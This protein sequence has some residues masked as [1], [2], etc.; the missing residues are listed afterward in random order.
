MLSKTKEF[1]QIGTSPNSTGISFDIIGIKDK[2]YLPQTNGT[3]LG[4]SSITWYCIKFKT[5]KDVNMDILE[6]AIRVGVEETK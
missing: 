1:Y 4:K 5:L 3:K 2:T 6:T